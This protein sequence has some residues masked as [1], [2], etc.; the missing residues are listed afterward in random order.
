MLVSEPVVLLSHTALNHIHQEG[1]G[2]VLCCAWLVQS[3]RSEV[4]IAFRT[5]RH[6]AT[7]CQQY[8]WCILC[9]H[10]QSSLEWMAWSEWS[11]YYVS[12]H[13]CIQLLVWM[14]FL[15]AV[16]ALSAKL[17][18][19]IVYATL[20]DTMAGQLSGRQASPR[21]TLFLQAKVV[22]LCKTAEAVVTHNHRC[23]WHQF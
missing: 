20:V 21:E 18:S 7:T 2:L 5:S 19:V 23:M 22:W 9:E 6:L 10:Y 3:S 12:T 14:V 11:T 13:Q 1:K 16:C 15:F 8:Q 17:A 4:I